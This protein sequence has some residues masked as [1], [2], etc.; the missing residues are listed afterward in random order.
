MPAK[1]SLM[2]S[3]SSP[4]AFRNWARASPEPH[5]SMNLLW[6][7]AQPSAG[8][9]TQGPEKTAVATSSESR[10]SQTRSSPELASE[11]SEVS[12]A[13]AS[14]AMR[15]QGTRRGTKGGASGSRSLWGV[16]AAT[17]K[18]WS[19]GAP[20]MKAAS[21]WSSTSETGRAAASS[22]CTH[23]RSAECCAKAALRSWTIRSTDVPVKC[24]R[25][26]AARAR[27]R[28]L[29]A[30]SGARAARTSATLSAVPREL[31]A[32]PCSA[33][34]ATRRPK[35]QLAASARPERGAARAWFWSS[36]GAKWTAR[37]NAAASSAEWVWTTHQP[38]RTASLPC[39]HSMAGRE[40]AA[41]LRIRPS[42]GR[43]AGCGEP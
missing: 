7:E 36:W 31:R 11:A 29:R 3:E 18:L 34:R 5:L 16:S 39:L 12:E 20:A 4:S 10:G 35:A 33:K 13:R 25:A 21:S 27:C 6:M 24:R 8:S 1:C 43:A 38:T 14:S 23:A 26:S 40:S 2:R 17:G 9:D 41:E 28:R 42:W 37:T 30:S 15:M 19:E 32:R 22:S